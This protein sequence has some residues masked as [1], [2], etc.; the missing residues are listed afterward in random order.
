[1]E[2]SFNARAWRCDKIPGDLTRITRVNRS[3]LCERTLRFL[4]WR[5]LMV[6]T[7]F[8]VTYWYNL[9]DEFVHM[10][11][12]FEFSSYCMNNCLLL[13]DI[14]SHFIMFDKGIVEFFENIDRVNAS[15]YRYQVNR[16][17]L[18]YWVYKWILI[19]LLIIDRRKEGNKQFSS[20]I[21]I[22]QRQVPLRIVI[23]FIPSP[24]PPPPPSVTRTNFY[25]ND[26]PKK[27]IC[28]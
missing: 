9:F 16:I 25:F 3:P 1:M 6:Y 8:S 22:V 24:P 26:S 15:C 28:T 13:P 27:Y 7:T 2:S 12:Y 5:N 11:Y 18:C 21:S 4:N 17:L 19:Q 14:H 10:S 20:T 23:I